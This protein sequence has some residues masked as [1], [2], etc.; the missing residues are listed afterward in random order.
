MLDSFLKRI[1]AVLSPQAARLASELAQAA[2][3]PPVLCAKSNAG[4]TET[5]LDCGV[6][7]LNEPV[8]LGCIGD[9]GRMSVSKATEVFLSNLI[10]RKQQSR[11]V[12]INDINAISCSKLDFER[13]DTVYDMGEY[14]YKWYREKK[15]ELNEEDYYRFC[16]KEGFQE[17]NT[18]IEKLWTGELRWVNSDGSHRMSTA[19]YLAFKEGREYTINAEI[20][21]FDI[22]KMFIE[23]LID[24]FDCY[25]M[26]ADSDVVIALHS[27]FNSRE[28]GHTFVKLNKPGSEINSDLIMLLLS[29]NEA[30]KWQAE[31]WLDTHLKNGQIV[32]L[33]KVLEPYCK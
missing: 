4:G 30:V 19:M 27:A 13:F 3:A 23:D 31:E 9:I 28:S 11:V 6:S 17:Q 24:S 21:Q 29:R 15:S 12:S 16:L 33:D 10:T 5:W 26:R 25:L 2:P 22:N 32:T 18:F 14:N 1:I 8:T 7:Y 20:T